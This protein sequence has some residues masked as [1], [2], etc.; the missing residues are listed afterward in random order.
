MRR[1]GIAALLLATPISAFAQGVSGGDSG[2]Q[3]V[4][5]L[6]TSS[7][8]ASALASA[9]AGTASGTL[10]AGNDARIVGALPAASTG[11][12]ATAAGAS[13][14]AAITGILGFMPYNAANPSSFI[15]ASGAPVQSVNGIAPASG[16]V[17]VPIPAIH[18]STGGLALTGGTVTWTFPVNTFPA[19]ATVRC[20]TGIENN[21]PATYSYFAPMYLVNLTSTVPV[22]VTFTVRALLNTVTIA[23]GSMTLAVAAPAGTSISAICFQQ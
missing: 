16:N 17:T 4:A 7:I 22:S 9:L 18:I 1:F 13:A 11:P 8:S 15:T 21:S 23:L 12:L 6:S 20:A 5:G 3:S 19:N 14:L 2:V 10:A